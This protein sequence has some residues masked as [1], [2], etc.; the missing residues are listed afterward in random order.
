[1][2]RKIIIDFK[3]TITD[4]DFANVSGGANLTMQLTGKLKTDDVSTN[5]YNDGVVFIAAKAIENAREAVSAKVPVET[6]SAYFI[7]EELELK[8]GSF[9]LPLVLIDCGVNLN[10]LS[11]DDISFSRQEV[12][13]DG[14]TEVAASDI[15]VEN[16]TKTDDDEVLLTLSVSGATDRNQAAEKINGTLVDIGNES[17]KFTANVDAASFYPVFDYV[18][19][20]DGNLQF[21]LEL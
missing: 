6:I 8:G 12:S 4:T 3:N 14:T 2:S 7:G 5:T 11:K 9:T 21:T 17:A 1:M 18:E 19:A 15:S 16:V 20:K 13:G 10:T